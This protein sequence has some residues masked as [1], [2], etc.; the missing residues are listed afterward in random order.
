MQKSNKADFKAKYADQI[1]QFSKRIFAAIEKK[2]LNK[3]KLATKL[4]VTDETIRNWEIGKT[5]PNMLHIWILSELT[6]QTIDY[7]YG[8]ANKFGNNESSKI[9]YEKLTDKIL[10]RIIKTPHT[11]K[12]NT[13]KKEDDPPRTG[14]LRHIEP[15]KAPSG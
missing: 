2:G 4:G 9:D 11:S 14:K 1:E 15:N 6:G 5:I 12:T 7:F 10:G 13:S 8:I 3:T